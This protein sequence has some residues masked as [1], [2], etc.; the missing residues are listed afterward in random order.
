MEFPKYWLIRRF[1]FSLLPYNFIYIT[2]FRKPWKS[3]LKVGRHSTFR[4]LVHKSIKIFDAFSH[5]RRECHRWSQGNRRQSSRYFHW[6][7][8]CLQFFQS[9]RTG[10]L[11]SVQKTGILG[12]W[13]SCWLIR[14][15][16]DAT[17]SA[18]IG[19]WGRI[20]SQAWSLRNWGRNRPEMVWFELFRWKWI[21]TQTHLSNRLIKTESS[22]VCVDDFDVNS[23]GWSDSFVWV[24]EAEERTSYD[25]KFS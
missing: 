22:H 9:A 19:R 18:S 15:R 8:P 2:E 5:A 7:R 14:R 23:V 1:V 4:N 16:K 17:E 12:T 24:S 20:H 21:K 25:K 13:N 3:K 6:D 10:W 11:E